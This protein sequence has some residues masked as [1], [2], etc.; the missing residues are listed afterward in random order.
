M[1]ERITVLF[2]APPRVKPE[3]GS[4]AKSALN[5]GWEELTLVWMALSS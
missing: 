3:P 4:Q 2:I 5:T 1:E